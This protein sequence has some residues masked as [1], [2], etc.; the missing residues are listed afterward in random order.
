MVANLV[1]VV[2]LNNKTSAHVALHF[3]NSWLSQYPRSIHVIYDQG[4]EFTGYPFQHL[5]QR[6]H[7]HR[8][9]TST[10]N[11]QANSVCKRMH[12]TIGNSLRVLS[13]LNPPDGLQDAQSACHNNISGGVLKHRTTV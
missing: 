6:L 8:H 10:K 9:P 7:V 13:T 5:P 11:P 3:E 4:G 12:Q 1:E 2:R